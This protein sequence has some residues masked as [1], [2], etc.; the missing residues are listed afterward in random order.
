MPVEDRP[1][2]EVAYPALN[3]RAWWIGESSD[4]LARLEA[5]PAGFSPGDFLVGGHR[6]G[7]GAERRI[8]LELVSAGVGALLGASFD[9]AFFALAIEMGLPAVAIEEVRAI[10]DGD[11]LRLDIESY[12][13]VNHSSGDR[14][15]IRN[16][17]DAELERYRVFYHG[18]TLGRAG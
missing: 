5:L 4:A 10:R 9:P 17:T 15:V 12:R 14:Y 6:C 8:V 16:L 3:G 13:V 7:E 2:A 11:S 18:G 1:P